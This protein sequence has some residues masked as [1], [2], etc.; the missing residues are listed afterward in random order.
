MVE[1]TTES[2]T[3]LL[4]KANGLLASAG[5]SELEH[6]LTEQQQVKKLP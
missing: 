6:Q 4:A 3:D 1:L 2:I 5:L